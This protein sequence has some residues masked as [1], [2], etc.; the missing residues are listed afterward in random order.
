[1]AFDLVDKRD[2]SVAESLTAQA[3][4]A[5][6]AVAAGAESERLEA[7][8]LE[9]MKRA[10]ASGLWLGCDCRSEHGRRPVVAPCRSHRGTDYWRVLAGRHVPHD[11][12]CVFHRTGARRRRDAARWNRAAVTAPEGWF[13]VLRDQAE[14][15]RISK[16]GGRSEE[17]DG[18]RN[19]RVRH[20]ALRQR[21]LMLMES[22]GLNRLRPNEESE[23]AGSWADALL[24]QA[25]AIEI[26]PGRA[27]ADLWFPAHRMWRRT[28]VH[29][30]VRAAARDWPAGHKPQGFLCWVVWDVDAHGVGTVE[31]R[32]RVEVVSAVGQPVVGHHP[33]A[34]PYL[35]LGA[36]GLPEGESG[37][38][39]LEA[40]AQPIV[41]RD[42]PVP[43]DSHYERRAFGTLR[44]TLRILSETFPDAAFEL[45]KPVFE[46]ETP[47]GPCLPDFLIRARRGG[48]ALA[49]VVEVMGF[50]RPEYLRGKEV[51]HP[52]MA[53]LGALCTMQASE[54]DR[55]PDGLK[56]EGRK[57][58]RAIR[59]ALQ[60]RWQGGG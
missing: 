31:R 30:R 19:S 46:I 3:Q 18:E 27:L 60:R 43:V 38:E 17:E 28:L 59:Q 20:R 49:F 22:A 58:T 10:R 2:L 26:A 12:G 55:P 33:I 42:C 48:D 50:E 52:R 44:T 53:T 5:V 36:V 54:F 7:L 57:V 1:M 9:V 40:Y 8:V 41:A 29:A 45:E 24:E 11:E 32:N 13:A 14:E 37:Y 25:K 34:P 47:D 16:P 56:A 39:C 6:R 21:L 35:F 15:Q 51:T 4:N 23:G